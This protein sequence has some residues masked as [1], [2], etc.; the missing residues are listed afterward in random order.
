MLALGIVV[1]IF[2]LTLLVVVHEFG[3]YLAARRSGVVVEEFG[4]GLPPRAWGKKLKNGV[5]F[6]INWLP[7]GGFCKMQGESDAADKKG[8]YGKAT[9]WQKTKILF[10][11]VVMNWLAAIVIF[12]ILALVG[13][14]HLIRGQFT[15]PGDTVV[16]SPS[17]VRVAEVVKGSPAD[18]AGLKKGDMVVYLDGPDTNDTQCIQAPCPSD[19]EDMLYIKEAYE[20]TDYAREHAGETITV[21][22]KRDGGNLVTTKAIMLKEGNKEGYYFGLSASQDGAT[23]YRSTWSAPIVGVATTVQLTGETFKGVGV[24]LGELFGGLAKQ[25]S[26][27]AST[28]ESGRADVGKAGDGVTGPVG[29][30]G[31]LFPQATQAGGITLLMLAGVISLSLAVMN[32]LPIPA[33][34]GGRWLLTT[35]YRL[36]R[37]KLT[38]EAEE[39]A[40]T[41]GFIALFGLFILI[42]I[43][44]IVRLF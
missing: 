38:Q 44:D 36:R 8:D 26:L 19:D 29:I 35:I 40:V 22:Y 9:Y 14:P 13:M 32:V 28:R 30:V 33:L 43:I 31:V 20:V 21:G 10:A 11:G 3:H 17:A 37:K 15:V 27:D 41:A 42:T 23:L 5:L 39:K 4:I 6:S 2:I 34:D 1:G 16:D 18:K 25:L 7:I 12:T 24:L